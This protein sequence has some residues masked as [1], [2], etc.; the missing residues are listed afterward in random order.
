MVIMPWSSR[1]RRASNKG[2]KL[3]VDFSETSGD[4]ASPFKKFSKR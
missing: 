2:V 3:L 4:I 1:K